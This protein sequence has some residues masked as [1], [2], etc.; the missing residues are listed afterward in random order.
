MKNL[1]TLWA[2][3]LIL[4]RVLPVISFSLA[5]LTRED[6]LHLSI[7]AKSPSKPACFLQEFVPSAV[8]LNSVHKRN[9]DS[10]LKRASSAI[11]LRAYK[12]HV[13]EPLHL[14]SVFVGEYSVSWTIRDFRR[15][16]TWRDR[17][18]SSPFLTTS[19]FSLAGVRGFRLKLLPCGTLS[20]KP[21]FLSVHLE[22][23]E[24]WREFVYPL[25]I[26]VANSFCKIEEVQIDN[27]SVK[28]VVE[29]TPK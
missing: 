15:K 1:L 26:S 11:Q 22:Q 18:A 29:V 8:C 17:S 3:P 12:K 7:Q 28:V 2:V 24:K 19:R 10:R 25:S 6:M 4:S 14:D 9:S 23:V 27:D 16:V 21:G 20:S 5:F 13:E